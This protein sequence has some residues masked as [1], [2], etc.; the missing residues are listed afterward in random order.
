MGR[1]FQTNDFRRVKRYAPELC[2]ESP[3]QKAI[4]GT[5]F[6]GSVA[7]LGRCSAMPN[8]DD[9]DRTLLWYTL[10][11]K[12]NADIINHFLDQKAKFDHM[13]LL[14]QYDECLVLLDECH[15]QFGWSLWEIQN[16]IAVLNEYKGLNAQKQYMKS[17]LK[18]A[19]VGTIMYYLVDSFS[20]QCER[21]VSVHTYL[22]SIQ[23]NYNN[24]GKWNYSVPMRKYVKYKAQGY[25]MQGQPGLDFLDAD[26]ISYFLHEDDGYSLIDRYLSFFNIVGDIY[27]CDSAELCGVFLPYIKGLGQVIHDPFLQNVIHLS[28]KH[29]PLF[30]S[31]GNDSICQAYDFYV[32]GDYQACLDIAGELLRQDVAFFPLVEIY[33][34]SSTYLPRTVPPFGEKQTVL[35]R[36][37]DKLRHLFMRS[38]DVVVIQTGLMKLL[39]TRLDTV[40]SRELMMILSKYN[41][42]LMVLEEVQL[43]NFFSSISTADSVFLFP[44]EYLRMYLSEAAASYRNS[45]AMQF[46]AAVRAGDLEGL[47]ACPVEA[48]RKAKYQAS[49]LVETTPQEALKVLNHARS[50]LAPGARRLEIDAL[51]IRAYLKLGN[52]LEA[53]DIFIL[54]FYENYNF[55]YIGSI[56]R[57]F[58]DI[59]SQNYDVRK[60]ILTPILCSLYFNYYPRHDD[61]DDIIWTMC[62]EEYLRAFGVR[63]P[64][65]LLPVIQ[66]KVPDTN[67]THFLAEV[68]IPNVM[69]RSMAFA[70]YDEVLQE[71]IS[72]CGELI[73]RDPNH[74]AGYIDEMHRLTKRLLI[75]LAKREVENGK[76]Y[77]DLEGV[78]QLL[79]KEICE[80]YE[81]YIDFRDSNL[82]ELVIQFIDI[83]EK[84]TSE[85]I[86]CFFTKKDTKQ[87]DMLQDIIKQVRDIF[88]ADNKYGLDGCLSVRIRHGTLES[89]LRSCFE[90]HN[91]IT[92]KAPDGTYKK[93]RFWYA[94]ALQ[95]EILKKNDNAFALFSE[96][97][98]H[99]IA[100]LKTDLL[101]IRTEETLPQAL[102]DFTIDRNFTE[103]IAARLYDNFTF[104]VFVNMML[105][106]MLGMTKAGLERVHDVLEDEIDR[107]F[108]NA[109]IELENSLGGQEERCFNFKG[110][111][112][113]IAKARTDISSELKYVSQWFRLTQAD[114]YSDYQLSLAASM[115]QELIENSRSG[116]ALDCEKANIDEDIWLRGQTLPNIVD[117]FNILFDNVIKHAGL[118][119]RFH[120]WLSARREEDLVLISMK[121]P[122][123]PG[124]IDQV[125]LKQVEAK[126]NNWD[127]SGYV[128]KEGGSGLYKIKKILSV[129]LHCKNSIALDCKNDV[130]IIE[131]SAELKDVL[132]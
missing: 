121:N 56:D 129:D 16:R 85:N 35:D 14:G 39:Y 92:T 34:K 74:K 32:K 47:N 55:I 124:T 60:S 77:V 100:H 112:D 15:R 82:T 58:Q 21:N 36:I 97:V 88:V 11:L 46:A 122:V 107:L 29:F 116:C 44:P 64:S 57:I 120:I 59:K 2:K 96:R 98:D 106:E 71:R 114:S 91:L 18:K 23:V 25:M 26:T 72:I 7:E 75:R 50:Q 54:A 126:L 104:E 45:I 20:R 5:L 43:R 13:F 24:M 31:K 65:A 63:K 41:S 102:F 27:E 99:I 94:D 111:R 84:E 108:Q 70:S 10:V 69:D 80:R 132:L 95:T 40:W 115:S 52:L 33:A 73:K 22:N 127:K 83:R 103:R 110:L 105:D 68:C 86:R 19:E 130:F 9:L 49:L 125:H 1:F 78:R 89:Q 90:R 119:N 8:F 131:I 17:T 117:I 67:L 37:I 109:L 30:Y 66:G 128:N 28:Q 38:E 12:A 101:Q 42:R 118:R 6:P 113:A 3:F 61:R 79:S 62:Y 81:R 51:R 123:E 53:M 76:I 93:N 4:S 48:V 87:I